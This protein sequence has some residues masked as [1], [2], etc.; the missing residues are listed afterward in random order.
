VPVTL[1]Y[2][3]FALALLSLVFIYGCSSTSTGGS[4]DNRNSEKIVRYSFDCANLACT[5]ASGIVDFAS[6]D[7]QSR[8]CIWN[9]GTGFSQ[10]VRAQVTLKFEK[11]GGCWQLT[12]DQLSGNYQGVCN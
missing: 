7:Y 6:G 10:C 5:D 11:V 4:Q 1:K 9:C 2:V 3:G 8:T 12:H